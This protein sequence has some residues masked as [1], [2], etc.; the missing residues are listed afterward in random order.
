MFFDGNISWPPTM[1]LFAARTA[2][3]ATSAMTHICAIFFISF[4][5]SSN[6]DLSCSLYY[7]VRAGLD[8]PVAGFFQ[9]REISKYDGDVNP[10]RGFFL[11]LSLPRSHSSP[12]AIPLCQLCKA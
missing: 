8:E 6:C 3:A 12:P 7:E 2:D 5:L 11:P 9:P 4:F 10:I 1:G